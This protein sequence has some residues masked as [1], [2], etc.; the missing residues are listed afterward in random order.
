VFGFSATYTRGNIDALTDEAFIDMLIDKGAMYG[1]FFMLIPVGK[2]DDMDLMCTPAQR[3]TMRRHVINLRKTKPIFAIDFWND[4]PMVSGCMAGGRS[5]L[6]INANGDIEPCV[7]I[8]FAVDN[9]KEYYLEE[10]F[11]ISVL[12]GYQSTNAT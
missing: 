10:G 9:I 8:H 1:W 3:D 6:H 4:G 5:Y 7:F 2:D 12:H 11:N